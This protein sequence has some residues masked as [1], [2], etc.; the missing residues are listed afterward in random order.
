M[1]TE[2]WDWESAK[3]DELLC[4]AVFFFVS[5]VLLVDKLRFN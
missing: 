3:K 2:L 4:C 5:F 1:I